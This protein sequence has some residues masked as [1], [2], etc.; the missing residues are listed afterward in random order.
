MVFSRFIWTIL[1]LVVMIVLTAV[2]LGI[3]LQKP[4]YPVTTSLLVLLLVAETLYLL[5]Y[6][7]RI[8]RDLLKLVNALRNE[9]PTLQFKKKSGDPYFSEIHRSFNEIIQ[10]FKLIRLDKE[11]EH[12]FF[13]AT[14]DHI[15]FG[16]IAFDT[17]GNIEIVNE[18]FLELFQMKRIKDL[19]SLSEISAELPELFRQLSHKKESLKQV[20]IDGSLHHLIFL[21]SRFK[22]Q[23]QEITLISVRDIS[24]E[25]DRNELEAW[26]KLLR[27]LRHE[28]LNSISPIKLLASNL[29]GILQPEGKMVSLSKLT[30]E[31]IKD[32]KTGLDTIH[33]RAT[34]LSNFLD[35]YSNLYRVP[36][37]QLQPVQV[38]ELL[39]RVALLF[40]EQFSGGNI[41][42]GIR[43]EDPELS[44]MMDERMIE[45]V[46]INLVK[47][48]LDAVK[49][50]QDPA[51]QFFAEFRENLKVIGVKDNGQG[52]APDQLESIFIP[53]YSTKEGGTG[54]GLSFSQHV[55]RLHHG[56][57]KVN[58]SPGD[59]SDFQLVFPEG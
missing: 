34:G 48:S 23:Q 16:I 52:I 3:F 31:E 37:L 11:A 28:I 30:E 43:C 13:S 59:G 27:V 36:D 9:D 53:F 57:L 51:I 21:A 58:T 1:S 29:S 18:A 10:N 14:V 12:H 15:Q 25:I 39:D 56:Q 19:E 26:Q 2:G 55:M 49:E 40:K 35:A 8:R 33:R 6:L 17:T 20:Q 46:L 50:K 7:I 32:I 38:V 44:I 54:I 5:Y 42:H 47:N 41:S 22:L 24:R 4:D 45:Q